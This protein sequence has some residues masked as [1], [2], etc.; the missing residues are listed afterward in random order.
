MA[1]SSLLRH[2][3]GAIIRSNSKSWFWNLGLKWSRLQ[4]VVSKGQ[5]KSASNIRWRIRLNSCAYKEKG[6][7]TR[8]K[9]D[10]N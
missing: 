8:R 7:G 2:E 9:H 4:K 10:P 3:T 5:S 1:A 6:Y